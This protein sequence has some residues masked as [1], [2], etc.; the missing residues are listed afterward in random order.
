MA[1]NVWDGY[2]KRQPEKPSNI[3]RSSWCPPEPGWLKFN[4]DGAAGLSAD[5]AAAGGVLRDSCGRWIVG[6]QHFVGRGSALTAELWGIL[7][8]LQVAKARGHNKIIIEYDYM[9]A[10]S[11]VH[12]CLKSSL[13]NTLVR[14]ITSL[15][16]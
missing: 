2:C 8:G 5:W 9:V 15:S 16:K 3:A 13:S 4:T 10:V 1:K 11:M 6:F 14:R 12:D 7:H